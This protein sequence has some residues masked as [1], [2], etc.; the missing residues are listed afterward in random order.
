MIFAHDTEAAL[1]TVV[2]LINSAA[3]DTDGLLTIADLDHFV[4]EQRFSGSRTHSDAELRSVRQLRAQLREI[5]VASEDE[6]VEQVNFILRNARALPQL[7]KHDG[8]D[9]HIHATTQQAPLSERMAVEAAMALVDV[10]RSGE[11]ERLRSCA[12]PDCTAVLLDL[13]KNRS[14]RYCDTGNCA[15][16]EHVRAYRQRQS[17]QKE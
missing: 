13:S 16:R 15:N 7:V 8:L 10:I 3:T 12:A 11:R 2:D 5:W 6:A 17:A 1:G 9:Y 4:A 14:K